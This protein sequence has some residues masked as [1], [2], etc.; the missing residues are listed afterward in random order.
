M[1][2]GTWILGVLLM[3]VVACSGEAAPTPLTDP[4]TLPTTASSVATS[5]S[6]SATTSAPTV[7]TTTTLVPVATTTVDPEALDL[8]HPDAPAPEVNLEAE[9]W[10]ELLRVWRDIE[11]YWVW[12]YAHPSDDPDH[13]LKVLSA[14]GPELEQQIDG[15]DQLLSNDWR[16]I[17]DSIFGEILGFGCCLDPDARVVEG[18]ILI[19]ITS[20][21][22]ADS[23]VVV[24]ADGEMVFGMDGYE[25][26]QF[27][28]ELRREEDGRWL[29]WLFGS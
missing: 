12:M 17:S 11:E 25:R 23:N 6:E 24:D 15:M 22:D 16:I 13:L 5:V 14:D 21:A 18:R 29:V 3:W 8:T 28:V 9:T 7:S 26:Q 4:T 27:D 19:V 20:R 1:K 2:Q 10:A